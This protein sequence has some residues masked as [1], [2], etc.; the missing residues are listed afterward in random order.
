V[1]FGLLGLLI[2]KGLRSTRYLTRLN[3]NIDLDIFDLDALLPVARWSL[4]VSL[5]FIGGIVISI[6]FQTIENLIQWPVITIYVVLIGATVAIFFISMWSTH[7]TISAVKKR[8][9]GFV[10][11]N[12]TKASRDLKQEADNIAGGDTKELYYAVAAW[13]F[14]GRRIREIKEWPL[15]AGIVSRLVLSAVSPGVVY[16]LKVI[17][18]TGIGY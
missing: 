8:E 16:A 5:A 17:L 12:L 14:Y 15:N 1:L 11:R 18:G 4:A 6:L 9:L 2:F 7:Q 3:Q 13:G 10:T